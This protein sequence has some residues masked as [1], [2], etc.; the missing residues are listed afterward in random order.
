MCPEHLSD[1][2]GVGE[3]KGGVDLVED[4]QGGWLEEQH[5]QDQRQSYERAVRWEEGS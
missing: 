5:R 2:L 1:V 4:V 3:V